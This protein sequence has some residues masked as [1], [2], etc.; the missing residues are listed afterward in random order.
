MPT[1]IAKKILYLKNPD[2]AVKEMDLCIG[3]PYQKEDGSWGC[4]LL[5]KGFIGILSDMDVSGEDS[6]Q[7]LMVAQNLAR[8]L[9]NALVE[10][11]WIVYS[12]TNKEVDIDTLFR[13]GV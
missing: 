1:W 4:P 3:Q 2:E 12:D 7:A 6:F 13:V 11:G 10:K 8:T 9:L 5:L